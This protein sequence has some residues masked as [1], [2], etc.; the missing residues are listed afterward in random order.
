MTLLLALGANLVTAFA[1]HPT[2]G[3][4][5]DAYETIWTPKKELVGGYLLLMY[6]LEISYCLWITMVKSPAAR[7]MIV[8]GVGLRFCLANL[9]QGLWSIFFMLRFFLVSEIFLLLS[10]FLMLTV[11]MT[12]LKY[13]VNFRSP[14]SWL[15]VHVPMRMYL[16]FL[17]NLAIW[18]NGLI[19]LRWYRYR[20]PE[21]GH[22]EGRW[23]R[24]HET[25]A[26]I[27]FGVITGLGLINAFITFLGQDIAWAGCTIFLFIAILLGTDK[28]VQVVMPL[29]LTASL[30]LVAL[31]AS[32]IWRMYELK[33]YGAIRL[34]EDDD[35]EDGHAH[36]RH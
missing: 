32:Y 9:F 26:W 19:A 11:W 24:E 31:I 13:P 33:K 34:P 3:E 30:Q 10:A 18:Q 25:H 22:R 2:L 17:I 4:V 1:F 6:V 20:G 14:F 35:E 16:L 5:N 7:E 23:E 36:R 8:N 12:L 21:N 27:A 28:P 29:I 15:F